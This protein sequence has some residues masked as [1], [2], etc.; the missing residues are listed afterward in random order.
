MDK[1]MKI[2]LVRNDNLGDLIC[3]TP[4]IEAL[5]KKYPKAQIDIVVNSYNFL[6]IRN[7]PFV[8]NVYVYTKP[9][10]KKKL[11]DKLQALFGKIKIFNQIRNQNYDVSI[12][13]RS[14]YSPSAEQFSNISKANLRIGVKDEKGRDKFTYHV[15]PDNNKHEIEFCYDFLKPLE[16]EYGEEKPYFFVEDEFVKKYE[17]LKGAIHFHISSRLEENRYPKEKFKEVIDALKYDNIIITAEPKDFSDAKWLESNT[18]AKFI[19]TDSLLD[20]AGIIKNDKLFVTLDG[21]ALHIAPALEVKTIAISG[22]TN[23]NKWYPWGYKDLV[24]QHESK[25][26]KHIYSQTVVDFIKK[27]I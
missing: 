14:E 1:K 4:A 18:N 25:V 7:N 10:H 12:V 9:K 13:F 19:K 3:T 24:L 11:K 26:A 8:D 17:H 5:R 16:V 2:L 15:T 21:G 20:L 23:M 22:K 6:G 27:H